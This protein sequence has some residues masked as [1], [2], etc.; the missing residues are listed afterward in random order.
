MSFNSKKSNNKSFLMFAVFFTLALAGCINTDGNNIEDLSKKYQQD[1]DY[2]SLVSLLPYLNYT[3]TRDDV[4]N[5]LGESILCPVASSCTYFSNKSIIVS[6]LT[7]EP[8]SANT[9]QS[10]S[11]ALI[12]RYDLVDEKTMSPQDQLANFSLAP[13]GE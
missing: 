3:M 11:L 5:I 7:D 4:E 10:F 9:C 2:D 13:V 6:C 12:V 8:V 1:H